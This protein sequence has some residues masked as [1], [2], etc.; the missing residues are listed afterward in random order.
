MLSGVSPGVL[1][2][3]LTEQRGPALGYVG[4]ARGITAPKGGRTECRSPSVAL[5]C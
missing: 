2:R 1:Q 5:V 3:G 4:G